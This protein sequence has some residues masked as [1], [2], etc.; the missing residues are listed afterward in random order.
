M[1]WNNVDFINDVYKEKINMFIIYLVKR[2]QKCADS[3]PYEILKKKKKK[4]LEG[5]LV[6]Y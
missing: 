2:L 6:I 3:V 1:W 4:T 5:L